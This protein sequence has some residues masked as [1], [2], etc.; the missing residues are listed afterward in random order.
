MAL[1]ANTE[2]Q[3]PRRAKKNGG[4]ISKYPFGPIAALRGRLTGSPPALAGRLSP[5]LCE[6]GE[7]YH[8][9]G[10]IKRFITGGQ[11]RL[12]GR[13][14]LARPLGECVFKIAARTSLRWE[15]FP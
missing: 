12:W 11:S 14:L 6:F 3:K 13:A 9:D 8:R 15:Q 7:R 1:K 2:A 5:G 10:L 4:G